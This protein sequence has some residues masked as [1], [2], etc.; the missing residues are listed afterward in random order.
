MP[1]SMEVGM[2][3]IVPG[4]IVINLLIYYILQDLAKRLQYCYRS[5]VLAFQCVVLLV[6]RYHLAILPG[7]WKPATE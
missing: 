5:I 7:G 2:E 6:E 1:V 3:N 4:K